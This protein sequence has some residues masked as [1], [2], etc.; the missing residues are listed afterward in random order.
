MLLYFPKKKKIYCFCARSFWHCLKFTRRVILAAALAASDR[1]V[2][3]F[4]LRRVQKARV[5]RENLSKRR[6][7]RNK[8][9]INKKNIILD[10]ENKWRKKCVTRLFKK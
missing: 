1:T 3:S 7:A 8:K 4:H 5:E 6:N 10:L 9:K 2:Y